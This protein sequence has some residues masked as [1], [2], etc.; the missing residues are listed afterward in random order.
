[1]AVLGVAHTDNH[2]HVVEHIETVQRRWFHLAP[3]GRLFPPL[4]GRVVH[5]HLLCQLIIVHLASGKVLQ[6]TDRVF[7]LSTDIFR[8][9]VGNII[10]MVERHIE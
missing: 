6:L 3:V 5:V 2:R 4:T 8:A 10:G 7:E 9:V 1:M